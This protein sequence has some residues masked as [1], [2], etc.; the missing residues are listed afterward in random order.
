MEKAVVLKQ[1]GAR[2]RALGWVLG[3]GL[4]VAGPGVS[5]YLPEGAPLMSSSHSFCAPAPRDSLRLT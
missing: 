2:F 1:F 4:C 5:P 3:W